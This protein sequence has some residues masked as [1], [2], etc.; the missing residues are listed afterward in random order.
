MAEAENNNDKGTY[1]KDREEFEQLLEHLSKEF[2][3]A[4]KPRQFRDDSDKVKDRIVQA[5]WRAIQTVKKH[6]PDIAKHFEDAL[7][8]INTFEQCYKPLD[9][10]MWQFKA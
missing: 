5:I 7:K 9:D 8:P 1:A 3:P 10:V 4:G 6:D 2:T